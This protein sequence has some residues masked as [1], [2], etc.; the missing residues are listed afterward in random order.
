M[1]RAHSSSEYFLGAPMILILPCDESLHQSRGG[2]LTA[3]FTASSLYSGVNP[4]TCA[5]HDEH[6][7][8]RGVHATGSKPVELA[9]RH[10]NAGAP[11]LQAHTVREELRSVLALGRHQPAAPCHLS[12][13]GQFLPTSRR[14]RRA[15]GAPPGCCRRGMVAGHESGHRYAVR[16]FGPLNG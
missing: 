4:P 14:D 15:L 11:I 2:S 12:L 8:L 16:R 3:S 13:P 6:P 1:P 5:S 7:L 10:R 9:D